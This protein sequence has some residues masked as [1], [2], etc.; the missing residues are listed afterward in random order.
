MRH[1][2]LFP[3]LSL[4]LASSLLSQPLTIST[5]AGSTSGGGYQDGTGPDARFSAPRAVAFDLAGNLLVADTGNH[6]IRLVTPQGVVTTLAG[7]LGTPGFADGT[8]AAARF[9][10]P[11]GI[12]VDPVNGT[13]YVSDKDNQVIRRV[14]PAGEVSTI[15]GQPGV[16]GSADASGTAARFAYPRGLVV[17]NSG[18][19]YVADTQNQV[20]RRVSPQG[21]ATT[22]AGAMRFEGS[23]DGP[24]LQARFSRPSDITFDRNSGAF[25]LTDTGNN[26]IRRIGP[27]GA[28]TTVAGSTVGFQDGTGSQAR[29]SDPWGI[30][31][32]GSGLL[33]VADQDNYRIRRVTSAGVVTTLAGADTTGA[34]DGVGS[35]A[36]FNFPSGVAVGTDGTV[37][38]SDAFNHAIRR[39]TTPGGSVSTLAGSKPLRGFTDGTG[40]AARLHFPDGVAVDAGGNVFVAQT[41]CIRKITP[42]GVTTTFAGFP[43]EE[44]WV[45]GFGANARFRNPTGI[46]IGPGGNLYVADWGNNTIRKITPAG[47]VTTVAGNGNAGPGYLDGPAASARF[48]YPW[49]IAVDALDIVYVTELG[50]HTVRRIDP[51]GEVS[52]LAGRG[53]AGFFDGVGE[54]SRFDFP[55]GVTLDAARNLYVTDWGNNVVRKINQAGVT[56]TIAGTGP[57]DPGSNDGTGRLSRFT[58]PSG[59]VS[60]AE[61]NL[62]VSEYNHVIRRVTRDGVVTTVAGQPGSPGNVNG[63]GSQARFCYPEHLAL[64]PSGQLVIADSLNHAV[65]LGTVAQVRRRAVRP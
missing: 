33:Y 26:R 18:I 61:G 65:R 28:V 27:D 37:Y 12:A 40:T 5:L 62:Y 45:D 3:L 46:A 41:N 36:R 51:S 8:G 29:F 20:I 25:Y 6:V 1:R 53:S 56:T 15:A 42:A 44:G 7:R 43:G 11:A 55:S 60:D 13:I 32:D 10:F 16:A 22:F 54:T 58:N 9:R 14:T 34:E 47:F 4:V 63:T 48:A 38:I 39:I 52:T 17:D 19:I 31:V 50:N 49:G 21:D 59:I 30:D 2:I 57:N 35:A 24:A 23:S 64:M